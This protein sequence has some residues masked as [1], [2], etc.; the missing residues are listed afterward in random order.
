MIIIFVYC[1]VDDCRVITQLIR[2]QGLTNARSK[3]DYS[4]TKLA[5]PVSCRTSG[6]SFFPPLKH[7][8]T[9]PRHKVGGAMWRSG[10][11]VRRST[12]KA[13]R[14]YLAVDP[15]AE[16]LLLPSYFRLLQGLS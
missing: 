16:P 11:D 3:T 1:K 4:L 7:F 5:V 9:A 13:P 15:D 6:P 12:A 14:R 2:D 10:R 8:S